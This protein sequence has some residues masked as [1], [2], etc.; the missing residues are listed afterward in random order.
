MDCAPHLVKTEEGAGPAEGEEEQV[1]PLLTE[2]LMGTIKGMMRS[3]PKTRMTLE[4][5]RELRVMV[6]LG[7]EGE[8][9]GAR[10]ALVEEG[11]EDAWIQNYMRE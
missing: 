6:R 4:E 3:D 10:A 5:V 8:Q 11:D 7:A 2:C 9:G 1:L